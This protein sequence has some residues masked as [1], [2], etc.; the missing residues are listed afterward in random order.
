VQLA[1]VIYGEIT[2]ALSLA[3]P[4]VGSASPAP[5]V[6]AAAT[7]LA[8]G[9]CE[10]ALSATAF[11]ALGKFCLGS[12]SL[13]NKLLPMFMRELGTNGQPAVRNNALIVLFDLVKRHT[14]LFDRHLPSI[15]LAVADTSPLVRHHAV[16]LL[17]QVRPPAVLPWPWIPS[18]THGGRTR[19]ATFPYFSSKGVEPSQPSQRRTRV[20]APPRAVWPDLRFFPAPAAASRGLH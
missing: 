17:A 14:A 2:L 19:S 12:A 5:E 1:L 3:A 15:A 18:A 20:R 10:P 13:A 6:V 8:H 16:V 11:V 7:D 4:G 9:E